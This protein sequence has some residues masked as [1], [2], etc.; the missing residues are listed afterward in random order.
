MNRSFSIVLSVIGIA[1][2]ILMFYDG[3]QNSSGQ[4]G[5]DQTNKTLLVREEF[6]VGITIV[7][8]N[9]ETGN[10]LSFVKVGDVSIA[11]YF[12]ASEYD[13]DHDGIVD[14]FISFPNETVSTGTNFTACNVIVNDASMSCRSGLAIEGRSPNIQFVLPSFKQSV[15]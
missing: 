1:T 14:R 10:V 6:G 8:V 13:L 3:L 15:K 11:R 12:N 2:S 5:S 7:G 4:S 9:N